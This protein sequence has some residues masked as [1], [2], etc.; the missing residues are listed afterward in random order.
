VFGLSFSDWR[1]FNLYLAAAAHSRNLSW[2]AFDG[3][4]IQEDPAYAAAADFGIATNCMA[5]GWCSSYYDLLKAGE[6]Q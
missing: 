4:L 5:D 6:W 1:S 2:G 3:G